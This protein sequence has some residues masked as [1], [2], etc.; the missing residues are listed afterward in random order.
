MRSVLKIAF[1]TSL[2]AS[3]VAAS[4]ETFIVLGNSGANLDAA[5]ASAGGQVKKRLP[6]IDAVIAEGGSNFLAAAKGKSGIAA[7]ERVNPVR[8]LRSIS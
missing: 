3:P 4:A 1:A 7:R 8:S 6:G 5:V 2:V